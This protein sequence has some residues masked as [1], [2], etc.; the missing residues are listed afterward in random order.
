MIDFK[1]IDNF[2][3][4]SIQRI[5][6]NSYAGF[7]DCFPR[8]KEKFY[9]QFEQEDNDAFNNPQTIGKYLFFTCLKGLAI[10]YCSWDER[11]NPIGILGQNCI[12]PEYQRQGYGMKQI[13]FI[14]K[15]FKD[16]KF[17][18]IRVITGEH[19]FFIPAQKMYEKCGFKELKRINGDL[20][21]RIELYKLL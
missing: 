3:P 12:L 11:Q 8:D 18:E 9:K 14:F 4:G 6:K 19:E 20:F 17:T 21:K 16:E 1:S 13:E 5:L 7:I 10:G 15:I 2:K